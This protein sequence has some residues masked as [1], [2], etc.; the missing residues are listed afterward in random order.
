MQKKL[1]LGKIIILKD[2][3]YQDLKPSTNKILRRHTSIHKNDKNPAKKYLWPGK[4]KWFAKSSGTTKNKSKY[5]PITKHSLYDCHYK[6]KRYVAFYLEKI[7]NQN[8]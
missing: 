1:C 3:I 7:Q 8:T 4:I 5:I 6:E 2:Q